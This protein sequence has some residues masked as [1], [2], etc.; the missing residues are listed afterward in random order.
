VAVP[1]LGYPNA[2]TC[3]GLGLR[4]APAVPLAGAEFLPI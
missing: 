4:F 3:A 2:A 1:A